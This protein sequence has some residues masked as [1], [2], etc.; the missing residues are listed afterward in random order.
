[1]SITSFVPAGGGFSDVL[2]DLAG[3]ILAVLFVLRIL[4]QQRP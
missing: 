2:L 3:I 1:M 4:R